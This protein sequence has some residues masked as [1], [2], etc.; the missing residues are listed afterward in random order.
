MSTRIS[1]PKRIEKIPENRKFVS[2]RTS[3]RAAPRK[4]SESEMV[5]PVD[6]C[7]CHGFKFKYFW[8]LQ[9]KFNPALLRT[10]NLL[11]MWQSNFYLWKWGFFRITPNKPR[12]YFGRRRGRQ[13]CTCS[14]NNTRKWPVQRRRCLP[15]I[16]IYYSMLLTMKMIKLMDFK[17]FL[18]LK[19]IFFS[20]KADDPLHKPTRTKSGPKVRFWNSAY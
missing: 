1:Y 17:K 2:E 8:N 13:H 9:I 4:S 11:K 20:S 10:Q 6:H 16:G 18:R 7:K 15:R 19:C 14:A 3:A 12:S 5:D